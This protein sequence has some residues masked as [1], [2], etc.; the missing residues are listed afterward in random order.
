M[1]LDKF[2]WYCSNRVPEAVVELLIKRLDLAE[3]HEKKKDFRPLPYTGFRH[4]LAGISSS[5]RYKDIL[6]KIR[7]RALSPRTHEYFWIPKLFLEISGGFSN[8]CID[9]L[10]EWTE[11]GDKEKIEAVAYLL[12]DAPSGF[13]F[14]HSDFVSELLENYDIR[15]LV[16]D[17]NEKAGRKIRDAELSKVPFMLI[18][19]E[20]EKESG[21][22]SVR[23]HGEGDQGSMT[24]EA[25]AK[26]LQDEIND[27]LEEF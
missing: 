3:Y 2:L 19:G 8:K 26:M 18:V 6:K 20:N 12:K 16:D 5:P 27:K 11:S 23:K 1:I 10:R 25:F 22:V 13:V 14:S 17:R 15:A 9:V 4:G 7:E 21:T 24:T